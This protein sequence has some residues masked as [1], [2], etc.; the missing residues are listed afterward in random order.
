MEGGMSAGL[1]SAIGATRRYAFFDSFEG[2][3]DVTKEDGSQALL[4]QQGNDLG[5]KLFSDN[6][7]AEYAAFRAVINGTGIM[8]SNYDIY[9][10]WFKDTV[11][12]YSGESISVLRLDGDWYESTLTCLTA[13][14][15]YVLP[16]GIVLI[17]DYSAWEGCSRAVH[18]FLSTL[19][20]DAKIQ[21]AHY[22]STYII[23]PR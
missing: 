3:P 18:E 6:N 9:V 4:W 19:E 10:G 20:C 17:D 2:L 13:L 21:T 1:I 11:R 12:R 22:G 15:P 16:G 14:W 5:L 7:R 23:K 8:T